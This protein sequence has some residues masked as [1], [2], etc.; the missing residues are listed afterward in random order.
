MIVLIGAVAG[1]ISA[2]ADAQ[3]EFVAIVEEGQ[4]T[5]TSNDTQVVAAKGDRGD[6][7]CS[8]LPSTL[9]VSDW[10]GTV[11]GISTELYG[12]AGTIM[13]EIAPDIEV[14]TEQGFLD[15]DDTTIDPDS[16]LFEQLTELSEGQEV[17]FSGEFVADE[18][19]CIAEDSLNSENGLRTPDFLMRFSSIS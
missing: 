6:A 3:D 16:E 12:D 13:I 7:I 17:T 19:Y 15:S 4:E 18:D 2:G 8:L 14:I 1:S 10:T 9:K 5:E 11:S